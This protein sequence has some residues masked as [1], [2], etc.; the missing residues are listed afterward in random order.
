M[1]FTNFTTD[2]TTLIS[3]LMSNFA[4]IKITQKMK[5]KR[6]IS[7]LACILCQLS[8]AYAQKCLAIF[9]VTEEVI[10]K[11]IEDARFTLYFN[12]SIQVPYTVISIDKQSNT[13]QFEFDYRPGKYTLRAEKEGYNEVQK[14]FTIASKRNTTLGLGTLWMKKVKTRQLKE[15]VVRATH[16][17]M[18]TRGDTVVYDAAAFDL[19]EGSML[20][21]LVAQL[22]GAELKD[23]QIKVNGKFIESLMV[24]GE[25][26]F[27]GNPKVALENLP[28]Y[29]VK[30]IKVYDRA[31]NDDYLKAKVNGK[32]AMGA[33]EHM[34]MDV[35][36]KKAYSN[37][38]LGNV[39]GGYGLP[40]D[41]YLGKAFGMGYSGKMRIAAFANLNNI[42]DTQ[43]GSSSGQ[44]NGGW[45]Q[46]GEL[47][48]KMGGLDYLYSHDRTKVFGNVTLTHEEP[49]VER[50][51]SNVNYF[52][53]GDVVERSHSLRNDRK[54]HLMSAHQFQYSAERAYFELKPSID[55]LKN[56]YTSIS[57]RAQF[58]ETPE[59]QYRVQSLDSLFAQNGMAPSRFTRNLLTRIG[60]D[61]DGK[62]DWI[63][64]NLAANTTISFP[65]TYD[66]IEIALTGNYRRD[67][68]RYLSS[69]NR[70]YGNSSP[71]V[72][73][74]DN[75]FQKSD[76]VSKTYGMNADIAYTW[77]YRP[78]QSG[79][80]HY[81]LIKP[82]IQY[83][84]HCYDQVNTLLHLHEEFAN[85]ANGSMMVPPSAISPEQLAVDL[86]NTYASNLTQ[87]KISPLVSFAY[88][89]VP[90][91][92]SSKSF[93]ANFTLRGD[94]MHERLDYDKAKLDTLLSRTISKF[95]PTVKFKYKDN[96][97]KI[98]TEI[99][100]N[101]SFTKNV[102]SIYNQLGT[103]NDSDP[104]N[105]YINNP[106]LKKPRTHSVNARYARFHNQRHNNVVLYASY[107]RTDNAIAQAR[108]YNRATG[109]STWMPKNI[110]GNWNSYESVQYSMPFG[111]KESFQFQTVTT[112]SYVHS[113]D[114][115]SESET[116]ERSVV[117]N[118]TLGE[119]LALSY[120][121]GKHTFGIRGSLSWLNSRSA[122]EGYD[123][124]SAFDITAG[125]NATL[126][127]PMNW[128][129]T[130]DLNLYN[131]NGYSDHT[132]NTTNWVW[133]ASV[134]KT[135]LKGNLTFR[136][137]AV[138]ILK[139]ISNVQH[140]VNAQGRTETWVNSQPRYV[141]L[142]V[143]YRFNVMPKK[144]KS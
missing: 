97:Q 96:G 50:K 115:A 122:R 74:G 109:V 66:N 14:D 2:F 130:T 61:Q 7:I 81:A 110:N 105:I 28:A 47:D 128:Q 24:N 42:K 134:A 11:P 143:V 123:N 121:V 113:V 99:E 12:D 15:A 107:G 137:N 54:L 46:D 103:I 95:T 38:W 94:I 26:F 119:Q 127:L 76:Y 29:T 52:N 56:D 10:E 91:V 53:T 36:L 44:W 49:E 37:G 45:A 116:F 68:N 112:A 25:D 64:A 77:N 126:N 8:V 140:S 71:N 63:I 131:R 16:I 132:L 27:A 40:S 142:H 43:M 60:N 133:N 114:Y 118:L 138:D 30:N 117:N 101:Y 55:Y 73:K 69:F 9:G 67:T 58:S 75:L 62:S 89:Y 144:K 106:G 120:R 102:P 65:T 57:R 22:P 31:A 129:I 13:Y 20:D 21:A 135:I 84:F 82:E 41:R 6:N 136:L 70:V 17:K 1:K 93:N 104:T 98:R 23:G 100:T 48:V 5:S 86:N 125:A 78:Y 34:V 87:N 124:I 33:D 83:D 80:G 88:L 141:M 4:A 59:E 51:G 111:K 32:K 39:E 139:Q 72:G 35:I 3:L 108:L 92:S 79:A 90:S 85:G 19:A 18:V